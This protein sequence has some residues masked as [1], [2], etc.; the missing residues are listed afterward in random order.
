M[1]CS[2]YTHKLIVFV[3]TNIKTT[4]TCTAVTA[5]AVALMRGAHRSTLRASVRTAVTTAVTAA[6]TAA[7][8]RSS[9]AGAAA[10]AVAAERK[11]SGK[12]AGVELIHAL[13]LTGG[14]TVVAAL[15]LDRKLVLALRA[16][17]AI[18][19]D[20][21]PV[22]TAKSETVFNRWRRRRSSLKM[23]GKSMKA[24]E[25]Q[26]T[27]VQKLAYKCL[28]MLGAT[29]WK[30]KT[31][32]QR[33]LRILCFDGGGTRGVLTIAMLK[34]IKEAVGKEPSELFDLIIGKSYSQI[35]Q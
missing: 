20:P 15:Q 21:A 31:R 30:P 3:T 8:R 5:G 32:G 2:E 6:V 33:G 18:N 12:N 17:A 10:A 27:A 25:A 19:D 24:V 7:T 22:V 28:A 4:G 14:N 9:T 11:R 26:L 16:V 35:N 29:E 34:Q 13:L 1:Y 23:R